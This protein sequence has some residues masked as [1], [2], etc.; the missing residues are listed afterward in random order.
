MLPLLMTYAQ[1]RMIFGSERI[2][3]PMR[4]AKKAVKYKVNPD[5]WEIS[6]AFLSSLVETSM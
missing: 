6:P 1:E 4:C 2:D 5:A 3:F